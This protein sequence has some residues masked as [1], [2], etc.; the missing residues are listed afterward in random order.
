MQQVK[1]GDKSEIYGSALILC[2]GKVSGD[3]GWDEDPAPKQ[4]TWFP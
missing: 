3:K 4:Q 1:H 2:G